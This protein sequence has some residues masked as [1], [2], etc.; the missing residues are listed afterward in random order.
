[1]YGGTYLA[2]AFFF[3]LSAGM[4]GRIKGS[5]FFMWFLIGFVLPVIGTLTALAWR[6]D[7]YEPRRRCEECGMVVQ[8][9]DQVCKRCG[10]DLEWP[11]EV[12]VPR[13][14]ERAG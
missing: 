11:S 2:I 9:H 5:S 14:R 13:P 1:M 10:R 12:L 6:W 8:L 3:G 7:R 4:V